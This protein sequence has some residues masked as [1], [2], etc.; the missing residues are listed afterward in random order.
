MFLSIITPTYN[1]AYTL[2]RLYNSLRFQSDLDFEWI[3]VNDGST[4]N[5]EE[6]IQVFQQTN[7]FSIRYF[8]QKNGGKQRAH[9]KGIWEAVGE[10]SVCVDSDDALSPDAVE[11]AKKIWSNCDKQRH[12]GILA[13]RGDFE[14]HEPICG[15]WPEELTDCTMMGLQEKYGFS[16]D[17][18]L[19]FKTSLMKEHPFAEFEGEKFVPEDSLYAVLDAYGTMILSKHVLYYCEYL[20][21]GLTSNY[22][23][24]LLNNPM[25]TSF[26]YYRKMLRSVHLSNRFKNAIISQAYLVYSGKRAEYLRKGYPIVM[27]IGKLCAPLYLRVKKMTKEKKSDS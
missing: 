21:D 12:I 26:C 15:D 3:V 2:E 23:K 22:R 24:L 9:N 5:T 4:D 11:K 7:P 16:G 14:K 20:P 8:Y 17:T 25:G 19:F 10:L 18:V 6:L 1:R 13:K 27:F